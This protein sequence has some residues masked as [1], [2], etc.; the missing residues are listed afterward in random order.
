MCLGPGG[1]FLAKSHAVLEVLQEGWGSFMETLQL[2]TPGL[3][4]TDI[5]GL[6][7]GRL[8]EGDRFGFE[9][10]VGASRLRDRAVL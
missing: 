9:G 1:C 5:G 2:M 8:S 7:G 10:G 3:H 4:V 6:S